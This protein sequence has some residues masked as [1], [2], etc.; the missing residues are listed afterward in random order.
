MCLLLSGSESG[1]QV[2]I[3]GTSGTP[4]DLASARPYIQYIKFE[5]HVV[6]RVATSLNIFK[7][8]KD[9]INQMCEN[10]GSRQITE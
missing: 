9:R 10:A 1:P 6:A 8:K 2:N 4:Y 3:V 5:N 7:K